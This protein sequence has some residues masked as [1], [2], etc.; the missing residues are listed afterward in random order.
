DDLRGLLNAESE[1]SWIL[2]RAWLLSALRAVGPFP[3]LALHGEQ[4]CGKSTITRVLRELVDPNEA[5]LRA[6]P[7][8]DRDLVIAANNSW[9]PCWDNLSKLPIWLSDALCRLATGGAF[10]TRQLYTDD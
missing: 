9:M 7:R 4:G 8:D 6:Q 1:E 5:A 3:V 2:F 10:A